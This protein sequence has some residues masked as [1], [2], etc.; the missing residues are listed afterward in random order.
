M[1]DAAGN[2]AGEDTPNEWCPVSGQ[3]S[4]MYRPVPSG[5]V[6]SALLQR[7]VQHWL[8]TGDFDETRQVGSWLYN[9]YRQ[10]LPEDLRFLA[11]RVMNLPLAFPDR[12]EEELHATLRGILAAASP[13]FDWEPYFAHKLGEQK[14][15]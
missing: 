10:A 13:G 8:E 11:D 6:D 4:F 3:P 5:D 12:F 1:N 15:G 14:L 2:E 9:A 7:H